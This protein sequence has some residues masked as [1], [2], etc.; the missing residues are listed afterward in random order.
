MKPYNTKNPRTIFYW[1]DW[2]GD[3]NLRRCSLAAKGLWMDLMALAA[4][5]VPFGHLSVNG[6]ALSL[7][8]L[9]Q[10]M[11]HPAAELEMLLK[12]LETKGVFRRDAKGR[13]YSKRM[14]RDERARAIAQKNGMKGGNPNVRN[15][16]EIC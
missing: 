13:I 4:I 15:Q 5:C 1:N 16:R 10:L 9:S 3:K 6:R 7:D 2:S 8:D 11:G 12:E 14:V